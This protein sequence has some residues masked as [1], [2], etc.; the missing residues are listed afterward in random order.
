M[1]SCPATSGIP[2]PQLQ[3]VAQL[4]GDGVDLLHG[5]AAILAQGQ[6][7]DPLAQIKMGLDPQ[8]ALAKGHCNTLCF[9]SS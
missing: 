6:L 3:V 2:V 7:E 4:D 8:I 9:A 5:S 1:A